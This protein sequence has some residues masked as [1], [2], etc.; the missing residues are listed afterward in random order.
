MSN[1]VLVA[2][3]LA[4]GVGLARSGAFPAETPRVLNAF[5]LSVALP[6]S[7]FAR[8]RAAGIDG[9]VW[10]PAS[11]AWLQLAVVALAVEAVGRWRGWDRPLRAS[12]LLTAGVA[13]TSF[14]GWPLIEALVGP[15]GLPT[16]IL[17]DQ[18]GSFVVV[19]T[20][21]TAVAAWGSGAALDLRAIAGRVARFPALPA[22]ILALATRGAPIPE[23]V[24][25]VADRLGGTLTPLALVSV[26]F[27]LRPGGAGDA[28]PLAVGLL[29]KLVCV[30]A[31]LTALYL[32]IGVPPGLPLRVTV[33]EAAMPPMITGAILAID[34]GL[35]PAL[36][37]RMVGL[38]IPL[39]VVTVAAWSR[40]LP[41]V[42]G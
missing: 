24:V 18:L 2:A 41:A 12:L 27:Q 39:G 11:M 17:A 23:A 30:P 25:D 29:L 26:G 1:L 19:S 28:A 14:V 4:L 36:A 34:H 8:M 35:A 7:V 5:V 42:T 37:G 22:L 20:V 10:L 6:A 21:G 16:A 31:L 9:G 40:L 38:G 13:N 15:E 33:L 32:A 3:C